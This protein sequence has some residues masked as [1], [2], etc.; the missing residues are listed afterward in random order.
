MSL[1]DEMEQM[2]MRTGETVGATINGHIVA[3]VVT[4][5][6][7]GWVINGVPVDPDYARAF[8]EEIA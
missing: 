8:M 1:F 7:I 3:L 2:V 5:E 4:D 6:C